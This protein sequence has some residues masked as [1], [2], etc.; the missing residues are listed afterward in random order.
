LGAEQEKAV[1]FFE[2]L[3]RP[4]E[5]PILRTGIESA[6]VA[7]YAANAYLALRIV[8]IDQIADLCEKV[9]ADVEEVVKGIGL[10][11]RIG[12]HYWYPGLGYGG[13]C[14]PKDVAAF[15]AFAKKKG[16][17]DSLFAKMDELN[18]KR[19]KKILRK[20]EKEFGL[21]T[22]KKVAV[23]GLTAKKRTD[24][25]RGSPAIEMVK[26]LQ[27][28]KARLS[29]FDPQA[30]ENA[31]KVISGVKFCQ[32]SYQA[33]SGAEVLLVLTEWPQFSQLDYAK[34]KKLMAGTSVFDS[35]NILPKKELVLLGFKYLG[36][37][38]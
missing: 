12:L 25:V 3:H 15:A 30:M 13:S 29:V 10:D 31:K 11:H 21:V 34:I 18:R 4:F 8:F 6:E 22:K 20:I 17:K 38:R 32:D 23:L 5:V 2:K 37:G 27:K 24:D 35:R 19:V 14:F 33:C 28:K 36:V 7:K 1:K 26:L 9:G 16:A